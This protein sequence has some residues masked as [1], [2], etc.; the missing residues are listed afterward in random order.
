MSHGRNS[1]QHMT[2]IRQKGGRYCA[3]NI[4]GNDIIPTGEKIKSVKKV[5]A[6]SHYE[7]NGNGCG[8]HKYS[9]AKSTGKRMKSE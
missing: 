3:V 9:D 6:F 7:T 4:D 2:G 1:Y 8:C 5:S